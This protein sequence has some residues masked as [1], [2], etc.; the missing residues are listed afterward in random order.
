MWNPSSLSSLNLVTVLSFIF[1]DSYAK[2][3]YV[4]IILLALAYYANYLLF[5]LD[6]YF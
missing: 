1:L 4:D 3:M 2:H 5:M 6:I